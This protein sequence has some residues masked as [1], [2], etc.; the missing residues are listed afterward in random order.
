MLGGMDLPTRLS[1][2]VDYWEWANSRSLASLAAT[3]EAGDIARR[4]L[5]HVVES[6]RIW[7]LRV[8]GITPSAQDFWPDL[9][10]AAIA[11]AATANRTA[12]REEL[13]ARAPDRLDE[14]IDYRNSR[15]EAFATP[16]SDIVLHVTVHGD[17]HRGQIAAAV[18]QAGGEPANTDYITFTREVP[19][20][21][22]QE[23]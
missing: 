19:R 18:R 23:S 21:G 20:D 16:V 2:L 9:T 3:P 7:L 11:E 6:E 8:Q 10:P 13:A 14:P 12:W 15:G 4:W 5:A 17:H 1:R 22:P